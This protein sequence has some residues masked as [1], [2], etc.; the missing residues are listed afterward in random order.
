MGG[1]RDMEVEV[2][3]LRSFDSPDISAL[4]LLLAAR[5][6]VFSSRTAQKLT[7][8]LSC[9]LSAKMDWRSHL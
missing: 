3:G 6:V 8:K 4:K 7:T 5:S 2:W 1:D 9:R